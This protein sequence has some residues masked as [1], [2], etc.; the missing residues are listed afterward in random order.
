MEQI[1]HVPDGE[2]GAGA[3]LLIGKVVVELQLQEFAASL[4]EALEGKPDQADAF[5]A[6]D[7]LVGKRLR[8]GGVQFT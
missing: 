6:D 1:A 7:L 3:D 2:S 5:E 8:V 4:V